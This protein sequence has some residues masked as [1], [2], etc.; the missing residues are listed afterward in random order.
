MGIEDST[1]TNPGLDPDFAAAAAKP[2]GAVPRNFSLTSSTR[3]D[4]EVGVSFGK[5]ATE[6]D[7]LATLE[8]IAQELTEHG[9]ET[10]IHQKRGT[11]TLHTTKLRE[12]LAEEAANAAIIQDASITSTTRGTDLKVAID[13]GDD[14]RSAAR[15]LT[16]ANLAAALKDESLGVTINSDGSLTINT[17]DIKQQLQKEARKSKPEIHWSDEPG[18]QALIVKDDAV[19]LIH[20]AIDQITKEHW[21]ENKKDQDQRVRATAEHII[22]DTLDARGAEES[23]DPKDFI[24]TQAG[25]SAAK[26]EKHSLSRFQTTLGATAAATL[27]AGGLTYA[28]THPST[29]STDDPH[30][31]DTSSESAK[32]VQDYSIE[33]AHMLPERP[34]PYDELSKPERGA[35]HEHSFAE[36]AER[37]GITPNPGHHPNPL[38]TEAADTVESR[39][40][41]QL[42]KM[43]QQW[44]RELDAP[45]TVTIH[46]KGDDYG[47][48]FHGGKQ[49]EAD[50]EIAATL[51]ERGLDVKINRENGSLVVSTETL[52]QQLQDEALGGGAAPEAQ[53]S[54]T[55]EGTASM[56]RAKAEEIIADTM[57]D[58]GIPRQQEIEVVVNT[59]ASPLVRGDATTASPPAGAPAKHR[60]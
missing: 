42:E 53:K 23:N 27:L 9:L 59:S 37:F 47:S 60:R 34:R 50:A 49:Y 40:V 10:E 45:I 35:L 36:A 7:K 55:P 48:I 17:E 13:F 5:L 46:Y 19:Y 24:N 39:H 6:A 16:V 52:R 28:I 57:A 58:I 25:K 11:L 33:P 44:V 29:P 18:K 31:K 20:E 15:S 38:L 1:T 56:V 4:I 12:H 2:S 30:H 21:P 54:M 26:R 41:E 51:T 8:N 43:H 3:G 22:R 14:D 32:V